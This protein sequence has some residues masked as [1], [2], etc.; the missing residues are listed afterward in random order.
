MQLHMLQD[1]FMMKLQNFSILEF[2]ISSWM[3]LC[4]KSDRTIWDLRER[5]FVLG[6]HAQRPC[7]AFRY[8]AFLCDLKK[9]D[10]KVWRRSHIE[11]F[12]RQQE[13]WKGMSGPFKTKFYIT[14]IL[15][16]FYIKREKVKCYIHLCGRI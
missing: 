11:Q 13:I 5:F 2:D 1:S 10:L 8:R 9:K 15:H 4:N 12:S 6:M 3:K 7:E 16:G 14:V